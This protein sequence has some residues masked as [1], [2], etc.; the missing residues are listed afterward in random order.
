MD[1]IM[2]AAIA[3]GILTLLWDIYCLR[4]S[5]RIIREEEKK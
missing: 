2:R 4:Y 1:K 3:L 5:E